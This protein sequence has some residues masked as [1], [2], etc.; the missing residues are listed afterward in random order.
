[1]SHKKRLVENI[2][3]LM[4]LQGANY[5]LPLI[6]LP[7]LVRVLGPERF[8]V[9][10]FA[11]A[12]MQYFVILT[13]YGFNL[14]A[15][16]RIAV[17]VDNPEAISA[18]FSS[19]MIIK[20]GLM[21][22]SLLVMAAVVLAVPKL[23]SEWVLYFIAFFLVLG[24]VLF[25]VWF[26]QGMG[27][28]KYI[29][30]LNVSAKL[31]STLAIF[32]FVHDQSHYL[33]A[34]G[35]QSSGMVVAGILG[36]FCL[37]RVARLSYAVPTRQVVK[38]SFAE[39]WC[40]F[41]STAAISL[42]TSSNTFILGLLTNNVTVGYFSAADKLVK[43]ATG[44]ISPI[45]QAIYPHI[46]A[47]A[48]K[49]R[50]AAVAFIRQSLKWIGLI[51]FVISVALLVLAGPLVRTVLGAKYVDSVS[52]LRWMAFLPFV[53]GLSN[54][55]GMQ[56]MLTFGM[57]KLFSKIIITAGLGNLL[58]I[59][60][61]AHTMGAQGAAISVLLIEVLITLSMGITLQRQGF[62]LFRFKEQTA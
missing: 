36:L 3:S 51:S 43:A 37:G 32:A 33:I 39:G 19:V 61:L 11:Q 38:E 30:L 48:A 40:I 58:I 22:L 15:T 25:P 57:N 29:T 53:V 23:R 12:F 59:I 62:D 44:V 27:Q 21:L 31:I 10:A 7:Y 52:V 18:I 13:D 34:A 55:F 26:Y 41:M 6:T 56:T 45:S 5:I 9:I 14:T 17:N 50:E 46:N 16:R 24:N 42:Y 49:S 8:G 47:L 60:P 1:M 20:I 54:I 35:I 28:M 2:S 4:I